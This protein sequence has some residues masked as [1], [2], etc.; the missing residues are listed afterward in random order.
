MTWFLGGAGPITGVSIPLNG[1][2]P[3]LTFGVDARLTYPLELRNG[4]HIQFTLQAEPTALIPTTASPV[5]G[6]FPVRVGAE[7]AWPTPAANSHAGVSLLAG[8]SW[9]TA[10]GPPVADIKTEGHYST[11]L[12]YG[13]PTVTVS[14]HTGNSSVPAAI[15]AGAGWLF[16]F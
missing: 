2:A 13:G 15:S 1:E 7:Y 6:A 5:Q 9:H 8:P 14:A 11:H 10:G 12:F 4:H 3:K 16:Q